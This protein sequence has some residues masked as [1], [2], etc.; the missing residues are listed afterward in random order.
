VSRQLNSKKQEEQIFELLI[1]QYN[2]IINNNFTSAAMIN[3]CIRKIIRENMGAISRDVFEKIRCDF[4]NNF[5]LLKKK[6]QFE[7]NFNKKILGH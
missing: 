2:S 6:M 1:V 7:V 4:K 5:K 3:S